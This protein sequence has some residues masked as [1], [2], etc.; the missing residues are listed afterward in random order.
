MAEMKTLN[1][2][3]VVD[4]KAREDIAALQASGGSGIKVITVTAN[5]TTAETAEEKAMWEDIYANENYDDYIVQ[6]SDSY[7][8]HRY[9][10]DTWIVGVGSN[11]IEAYYDKKNTRH[12]IR[13]A[14]SNGVFSSK[15]NRDYAVIE[16]PNWI[17]SNDSSLSVATYSHVKVVGYWN[18]D[19][20]HLTTYDISASDGNAIGDLPY[21][22]FYVPD[23]YKLYEQPIYFYVNSPWLQMECEGSV[24]QNFT[25]LGFWYWG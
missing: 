11:Y 13:V 17:W 3:E 12:Y 5:V 4:A 22:R 2:Y 18:N 8:G 7:A 24:V 6:V 15:I 1:G 14:L 16:P 19:S 25:P 23:V 9:T 21:R 20:S 10:I